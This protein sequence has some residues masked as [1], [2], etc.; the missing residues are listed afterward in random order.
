[1]SNR[2]IWEKLSKPPASALKEIR[3]GRLKGKSDINP[4]WR[5]KAMTD[6]FGPCG[7]GWRY[8]IVTTWTQDGANGEVAQFAQVEVE[9]RHG[10]EWSSPIPGV[11][12]SMLVAK[13]ASGH[14]TS[15]EAVKMAVTDA[16]SVALKALGVAAAIYEGRWDGS[17]YKDDTAPPVPPLSRATSPAAPSKP[18]KPAK[19][20]PKTTEA[21]A[22]TWFDSIEPDETTLTKEAK[23]HLTV[24]LQKL[25]IERD[26]ML[27]FA[28]SIDL[29]PAN[30]V[31]GDARKMIAEAIESK[32]RRAA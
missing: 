5:L 24:E 9:Y 15:D 19:A 11:G 13:E 7:V 17:K 31:F 3:A 8:R 28:R 12:G 25:G 4:Q 6:L 32:N 30:L 18:A 1:M 10:D 22:G 21:W 23:Y 27:D 2:E 26:D 20:G 16:L 14:H 29:D